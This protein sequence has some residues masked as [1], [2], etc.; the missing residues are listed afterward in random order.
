M[1]LGIFY[2]QLRQLRVIGQIFSKIVY[3]IFVSIVGHLVFNFL[4]Y[5]CFVSY[6]NGHDMVNEL[7]HTLH[8]LTGD[9][10]ESSSAYTV[11]ERTGVEKFKHFFY[12]AY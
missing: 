7:K 12:R 9:E 3:G 8:D 10:T 4:Y 1:V 5:T 2:Y 6:P 11:T